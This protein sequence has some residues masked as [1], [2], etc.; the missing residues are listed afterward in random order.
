MNSMA[1]L[2]LLFMLSVTNINAQ[3]KGVE[4]KNGKWGLINSSGKMLTPYLYQN[5]GKFSGGTGFGRT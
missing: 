5:I 2:L 3:V 1:A 4:G